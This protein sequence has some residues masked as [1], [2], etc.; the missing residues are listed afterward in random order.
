MPLEQVPL[1]LDNFADGK[2]AAD[3]DEKF[4]WALERFRLGENGDI[5]LASNKATIT[6]KLYI[7]L[8]PKVGGFTCSFDEPSVKLPAKVRSG[9]VA[10]QR[11]GVLV[12]S[13]EAPAEQLNLPLGAR[14]VDPNAN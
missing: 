3:V 8:D 4:A 13:S 11:N 6:L 5:E 12:V 2:L 9:T 1:T 7:E 10:V 14:R